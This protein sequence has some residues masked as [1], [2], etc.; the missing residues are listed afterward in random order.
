MAEEENPDIFI[1]ALL[2]QMVIAREGDVRRE[3]EAVVG[4]LHDLRGYEKED[5][6][7]LLQGALALDQELEFDLLVALCKSK[8]NDDQIREA[9]GLL[10]YLARID[11]DVSD[12]EEK[13]F[14]QICLGLGVSIT[15]GEVEILR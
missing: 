1:C 5:V 4:M 10:T 11:G 6:L 3:F 2:A 8:L 15:E 9:I 7:L 14:A 12:E 13:M